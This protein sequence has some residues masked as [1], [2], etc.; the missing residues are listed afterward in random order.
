MVVLEHELVAGS[1]EP[2]TIC[3]SADWVID[4]NCT[5]VLLEVNS[6]PAI[7]DGTM[8]T[9]RRSVYTKLV[10]DVLDVL[11]LPA[12]EGRRPQSD[13]FEMVE[14]WSDNDR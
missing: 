1:S 3:M 11:V 4:A 9:V 5:P 7:G 6:H 2:C 14:D 12:L 10:A 8:T 13:G